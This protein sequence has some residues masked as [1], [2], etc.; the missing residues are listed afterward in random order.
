MFER[1]TTAEPFPSATFMIACSWGLL[2]IGV[3]LTALGYRAFEASN[4]VA[5]PTSSACPAGL[6]CFSLEG[7]RS[8]TVLEEGAGDV[9]FLGTPVLTVIAAISAWR[10]RRRGVSRRRLLLPWGIMAL[11]GA[12]TWGWITVLAFGK[13]PT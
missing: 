2:A 13:L 6:D 4:R 10:W 5:S 3:V 1:A 9:F 11:I 12:V 7:I 8:Q